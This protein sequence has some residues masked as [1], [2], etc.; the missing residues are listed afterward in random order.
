[1]KHETVAQRLGNVFFWVFAGLSVP[2]ALAA[3]VF[4]CAGL[5][6]GGRYLFVKS[7]SSEE[8]FSLSEI[9][10]LPPLP[11]GYTL[12]FSKEQLSAAKS[13]RL[14]LAK[15][16][17]AYASLAGGAAGL[18]YAVGRAFRYILSGA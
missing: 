18:L 12:E 3:A 1:M 11:E 13:K 6:D 17:F 7:Y 8:L 2:V 10:K 4:A 9:A 5:W 15:E 14:D 16:N